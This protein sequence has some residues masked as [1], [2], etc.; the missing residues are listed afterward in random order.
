MTDGDSLR[1]VPGDAGFERRSGLV[2]SLLAHWTIV[3]GTGPWLD[4][5]LLARLG[6]ALGWPNLRGCG[7]SEQEVL[8]LLEAEDGDRPLL[9]ILIDSIAAD[10]GCD[11]ILRLRRQR[12]DVQ[13]LLLV[14]HDR[15]D[16]LEALRD[17]CSLAIV[18]VESFGSGT[19]IQ[20]LQALRCSTPFLDPRLRKLLDQQAPCRLTGRERQTL[21]GLAR[22]G[23]NRS[24]AA[25]LSIAPATVRDYVS[26]LCRKLAAANRTE[27]VSRAIAMG[28]IEP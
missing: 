22:G 3:A 6:R 20:A 25:A 8:Q 19:T 28:L 14:Q 16:W 21:E 2:D 10:H 7:I 17:A 5:H 23:S 1:F 4:A 11:L 24:I 13:V 12:P 26:S 27:V 18:H 15:G 9:L